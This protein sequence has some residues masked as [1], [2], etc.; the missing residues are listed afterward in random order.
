ME[1]LNKLFKS[2]MISEKKEKKKNKELLRL[3]KHL[4]GKKETKN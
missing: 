1:I 4:D 3:Q 2:L